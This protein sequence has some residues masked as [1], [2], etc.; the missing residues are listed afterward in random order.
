M[1]YLAKAFLT[2]ALAV[3]LVPAAEAKIIVQP[4]FQGTLL[5]TSPDGKV[6]M[7]DAGEALPEI[8][9][10]SS[11][12][13]FGGKLS[14]STEAKDSVKL[15]CLGSEASVGG[16]ASATLGCGESDGKLNVVKGPVQVAQPDG[17]QKNIAEGEEYSIKSKDDNPQNPPATSEETPLGT[18]TQEVPPPDS[19]SIETSPSQ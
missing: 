1:S 19:R 15:T 18:T 4:D 17:A 13:V 9:S 8:A 12:E 14:V 6:Q 16:G 5:V 3:L 7:F 10:G 11:I 2:A